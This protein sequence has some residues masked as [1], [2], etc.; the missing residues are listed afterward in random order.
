MV[1]KN[2]FQAVLLRATQAKYGMNGIKKPACKKSF[3]THGQEALE[4]CAL[5]L[6]YN[7]SPSKKH[8][9]AKFSVNK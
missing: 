5:L 8:V 4:A 1:D 9:M 3:L 6:C 7:S 2:K